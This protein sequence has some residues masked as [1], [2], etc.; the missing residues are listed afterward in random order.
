[1]KSF[2]ELEAEAKEVG[3]DLESLKAL[4]EAKALFHKEKREW[5]KKYWEAFDEIRKI[6]QSK[7]ILEHPEIA[8][9]CHEVNATR[10]KWV[11]LR[12]QVCNQAIAAGVQLPEY[13]LD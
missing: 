12:D 2:E 7:F 1:M 4:R 6:E 5:E 8:K 13:I 3:V 11:E 10:E 9:L